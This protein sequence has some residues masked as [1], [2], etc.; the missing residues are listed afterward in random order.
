MLAIK[1]PTGVRRAHADRA[2]FPYNRKKNYD[3]K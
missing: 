3:L 1:T 2:S